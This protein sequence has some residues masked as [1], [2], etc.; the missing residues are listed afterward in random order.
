MNLNPLDDRL[1]REIRDN[2]HASQNISRSNQ[3][4]IGNWYSLTPEEYTLFNASVIETPA[5]NMLRFGYGD[6]IAAVVGDE[7]IYATV[8]ALS[9][10]KNRIRL[11]GNDATGI[12]TTIPSALYLSKFENPNSAP[13]DNLSPFGAPATY[14]YTELDQIG[15]TTNGNPNTFDEVFGNVAYRISGRAVQLIGSVQFD[16]GNPAVLPTEWYIPLPVPLFGG[17]PVLPPTGLFSTIL[18][19]DV[20]DEN[21]IVNNFIEAALLNNGSENVIRCTFNY[22]GTSWTIKPNTMNSLELDF[23]YIY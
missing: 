21:D 17:V 11:I 14:I 10:D 12:G 15:W 18:K 13:G 9:N 6:R 22:S 7:Y 4:P 8:V 16:I 19:G 20:T 1:I 5:Q 3:P 2:K 23:T